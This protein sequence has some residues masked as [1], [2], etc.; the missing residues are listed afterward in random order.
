MYRRELIIKVEI[1]C[2]FMVNTLKTI[3]IIIP[4]DKVGKK[5]FKLLKK[6]CLFLYEG[7]EGIKKIL[8]DF[9][10]NLKSILK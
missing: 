9:I 4:A 7:V 1:I 8:S 10:H 5:C 3:A 2:I 6:P